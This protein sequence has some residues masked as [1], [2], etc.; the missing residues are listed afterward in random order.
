[1]KRRQFITLLGGAAAWPLPARAQRSTYLALGSSMRLVI[2]AVVAIVLTFTPG[3]VPAQAPSTP[4]T[5]EV[6]PAS[7]ERTKNEIVKL[8]TLFKMVFERVR[9]DYVDKPDEK[10]LLMAAIDS[11]QKAFP[12]AQ[13]TSIAGKPSGSS[14]TIRNATKIELDDVYNV[15]MQ[16]LN[17]NKSEGAQPGAETET[18]TEFPALRELRLLKTAIEGMVASLDLHSRYFDSKSFRELQRDGRDMRSVPGPRLEG[19][20][21]GFI[22]VTLF[23]ESAT[24]DLKKA[25]TDLS[26]QAGEKLKGFIIDLR[27]NPG[28]LL[29]QPISVSDVFLEKGAEIVSTRGRN[30]ETR[31]YVARSG[32]LTKGKPIVVL[33]NRGSEAA[34]EIVAAALQ[35]HKRATLIG[36]RTFGKGSVQTVIPLG[37]GNGALALTTARLL[38]P[39]GRPIEGVGVTPN[40][41]VLQDEEA[42]Q[43]RADE[44]NQEG[45]SPIPADPKNDKALRAAVDLLHGIRPR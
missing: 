25:I 20:D 37:S 9:A 27:N 44:N 10:K 40:F 6:M 26:F 38:R 18:E 19:D 7:T 32:D 41:K 43:P 21:V 15:A 31:R 35:D 13:R 30:A 42:S 16:I 2:A 3:S 17:E 34:A 11:M 28:G 33:I 45:K 36:T 29:D 12:S 24:V 22:R 39:S 4:P 23:N 5:V 1:V 14:A 8:F